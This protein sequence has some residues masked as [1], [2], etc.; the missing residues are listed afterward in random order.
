M[1][2]KSRISSISPEFPSSVADLINLRREFGPFKGR[3]IWQPCSAWLTQLIE[4][5]ETD[6]NLTEIQIQ[7][8]RSIFEVLDK[9][10]Y[11][12]DINDK[13]GCE[14]WLN[15]T[16]DALA[17][18]VE[19]EFVIHPHNR[20]EPE[21]SVAWTD[22]FDALADPMTQ[23]TSWEI[24]GSLF[25]YREALSPLTYNANAIY[26]IDPYFN[27]LKTPYGGFDLTLEVLSLAKKS[28]R[29]AQIHLITTQAGLSKEFLANDHSFTSLQRDMRTEFAHRLPNGVKLIW[30]LIWDDSKS[31]SRSADYFGMHDRYFL[32]DK[33]GLELSKGFFVRDP[34]NKRDEALNIRYLE[35]SSFKEKY[36]RYV[37]RVTATT[38]TQNRIGN[39]RIERFFVTPN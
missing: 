25:E 6:P 1:T 20:V 29:C 12:L 21:H 26:L 13:Q 35:A 36:E 28:K 9:D 31:H 22:L 39:R 15:A 3:F 7:K 32:T 5:V 34:S 17:N 38:G 27:P 24:K 19:F 11:L 23:K 14:D 10:G 4:A 30:H 2:T 18:G 33:G 16:T 8:A 37:R